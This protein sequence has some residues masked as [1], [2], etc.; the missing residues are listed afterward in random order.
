MLLERNFSDILKQ[1]KFKKG[2]IKANDIKVSDT[3]YE[4]L[5]ETIYKP[6]KQK[7]FK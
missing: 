2:K 4:N 3:Q 1:L 6:R 7:R 5:R